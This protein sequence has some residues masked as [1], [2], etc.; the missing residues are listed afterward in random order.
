MSLRIRELTWF[1]ASLMTRDLHAGLWKSVYMGQFW[2][3]Q[4]PHH[5]LCVFMCTQHLLCQPFKDVLF[6]IL[7][8]SP[9]P[10][11]LSS[12]DATFP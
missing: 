1:Y 7:Q 9:D 6:T 3:L 4:L 10:G 8:A 12:R 5:P 11:L 2:S